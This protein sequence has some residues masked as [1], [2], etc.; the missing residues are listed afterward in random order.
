MKIDRADLVPFLKFGTIGA[1]NTLFHSGCV[2][3]AH[4]VMGVPVMPSHMLA[5]FL[6]NA[7][8]Y[9]LNSYL[10]FR[11]PPGWSSYMRFVSVSLFSL[12]STLAIAGI[13]E[14]AKLDY[15]IGLVIVVLISP[16]VTYALQKSFTFR[17][18]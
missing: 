2:V 1:A 15:R 18:Q 13:C 11:S 17:A 4:G 12:A 14:F 16:P 3:L 5:F 9:I 8:S 7:F 10:V 6:V